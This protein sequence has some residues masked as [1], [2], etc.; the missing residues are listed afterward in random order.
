[1][2]R[3]LKYSKNNE[4]S[5][6]YNNNPLLTRASRSFFHHLVVPEPH[7]VSKNNIQ[8]FSAF[9]KSRWIREFD[10]ANLDLIAIMTGPVASG[11]GF[12]FHF[13]RA[14]LEEFGMASELIYIAKKKGQNSP[15]K[16]YF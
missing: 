8:E 1:M 9:S 16:Q 10:K 13:L 15:Y 4:Q 5:L 6:G 3:P 11:F 2:F 7:G 12:G 14:I